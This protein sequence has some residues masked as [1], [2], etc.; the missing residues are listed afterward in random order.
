MEEQDGALF[1]SILPFHTEQS[2]SVVS[3]PLPICAQLAKLSVNKMTY[4]NSYI[5]QNT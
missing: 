2:K 3:S 1:A 5:L 4:F